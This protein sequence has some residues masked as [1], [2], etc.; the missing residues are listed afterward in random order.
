MAA[1]RWTLGRSA[2][3]PAKLVD[4]SQATRMIVAYTTGGSPDALMFIR[5]G[6]AFTLSR[7]EAQRLAKT[8]AKV[9]D[10]DG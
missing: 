7:P 6:H 3:R 2:V 1:C 4:L 10:A 5:G 8:L 9:E